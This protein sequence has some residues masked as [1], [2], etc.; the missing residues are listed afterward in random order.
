[1]THLALKNLSLLDLTFVLAVARRFKGNRPT[2][3]K[4]AAARC[5]P[6]MSREVQPLAN[7]LKRRDD[8]SAW[9]DLM[10]DHHA[11]LHHKRIRDEQ[12]NDGQG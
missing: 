9:L 7:Q 6:H 5:A 11:Y 12:E 8:L 2:V 4:A 3:L 1:M 10:V